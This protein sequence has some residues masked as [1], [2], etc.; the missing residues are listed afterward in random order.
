MKF[1]RFDFLSI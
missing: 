1:L